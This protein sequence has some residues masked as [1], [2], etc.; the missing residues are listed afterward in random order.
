L[1]EAKISETVSEI[2]CELV[3]YSGERSTEVDQLVE[4]R[5]TERFLRAELCWRSHCGTIP[6]PLNDISAQKIVIIDAGLSTVS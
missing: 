3:V 6:N 2:S 1:T 5:P 4:V